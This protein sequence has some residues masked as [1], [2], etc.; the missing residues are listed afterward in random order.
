[1]KHELLIKIG[2]EARRKVKMSTGCLGFNP[3]AG[4]SGPCKEA[5]VVNSSIV[6]WKFPDGHIELHL[7]KPEKIKGG[8]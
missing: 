6:G 8:E 7:D 1:M 5:I 2:R 3:H 4:K